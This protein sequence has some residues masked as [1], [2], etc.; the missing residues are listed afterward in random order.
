MRPV[1][2]ALVVLGFVATPTER[3]RGEKSRGH[4]PA[5]VPGAESA[6]RG[7]VSPSPG[8]SCAATHQRNPPLLPATKPAS[9]AVPQEAAAWMHHLKPHCT[10]S[11][12]RFECKEARSLAVGGRVLVVRGSDI[13]NFMPMARDIA[14][15]MYYTGVDPL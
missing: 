6:A 12:D 13:L 1:I 2:L 11:G 14:T 4:R 7:A 8:D 15:C 3:L 9:S 10:I 5:S